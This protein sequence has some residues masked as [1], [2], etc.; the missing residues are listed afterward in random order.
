MSLAGREVPGA[1]QSPPGYLRCTRVGLSRGWRDRVWR[2]TCA[3][4]TMRRLP[5][6][7]ARVED[8]ADDVN[9]GQA[10]NADARRHVL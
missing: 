8:D 2:R 6:D 1:D 7:H 9:R 5:R 4:P 3:H 10:D